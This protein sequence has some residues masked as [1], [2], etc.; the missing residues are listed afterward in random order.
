MLVEHDDCVLEIDTQKF[1]RSSQF[2]ASCWYCWQYRWRNLIRHRNFIDTC[3]QRFIF[4]YK[5]L[6]ECRLL[7]ALDADARF[8]QATSWRE[9]SA[10]LS[11]LCSLAESRFFSTSTVVVSV[12]RP[13]RPRPPAAG[14]DAQVGPPEGG[15]AQRVQNLRGNKACE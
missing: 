11:M 15:V 7:I 14:E 1:C 5:R 8:F 2:Q 12:L 9:K 6:R 10:L 4:L 3:T 13:R